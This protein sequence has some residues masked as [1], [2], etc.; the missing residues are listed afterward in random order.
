MNDI[1]L[2]KQG[3]IVLK[4][5]NKR[6]FESRLI[7]NIKRRLQFFGDFNIYSMQST[8]YVEPKGDCDMDGA[9]EACTKIFGIVSDFLDSDS[10]YRQKKG[11]ACCIATAGP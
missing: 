3:E 7:S 8:I 2:L 4:G 9:F 6:S 5:L 11:W 1:I 10:S